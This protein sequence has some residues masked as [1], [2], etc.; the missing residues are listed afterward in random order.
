MISNVKNYLKMTEERIS[1]LNYMSWLRYKLG[2]QEE[3]R[4]KDNILGVRRQIQC[5]ESGLELCKNIL[6]YKCVTYK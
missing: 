5:H 2:E 3:H 1:Q 6:A 4:L